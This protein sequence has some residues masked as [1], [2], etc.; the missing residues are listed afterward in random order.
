MNN[1]A[2][3]LKY[4]ETTAGS[5][6]SALERY[7]VYQN[8]LDAKVNILTASLKALFTDTVSKDLYGSIVQATT[9]IVKFL[10]STQALKGTFA[11]LAALGIS[12]IFVS[13]GAGIITAYKS[14]A[15]L[16][17]AMALLKKGNS[18]DSV[19]S[20]NDEMGKCTSPACKYFIQKKQS[21]K[22]GIIRTDIKTVFCI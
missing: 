8:S 4:F 1:Y 10:D 18:I 9:G 22:S 13:M 16:T 7:G 5:A 12:K 21:L 15:Q 3:A 6:G 19:I 14:T 20:P 17:S 11:G 2:D